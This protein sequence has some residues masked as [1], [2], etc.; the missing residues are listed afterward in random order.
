MTVAAAVLSGRADAGLGILAAARALKLD[1][2]PLVREDY[3]L[4]IPLEHYGAP[5]IQA[6]LEVI[7]SDRFKETIEGLG[8][9]S[10]E[11]SG[12]VVYEQ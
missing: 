6:L 3:Q 1:F 12:E 4:V 9:Y 8:G 11:G 2:V 7:R 10:L 5:K